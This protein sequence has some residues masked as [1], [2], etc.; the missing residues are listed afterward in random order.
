MVRAFLAFDEILEDWDG[1]HRGSSDLKAMQRVPTN[2]EVRSI[3]RPWR[4]ARWRDVAFKIWTER[5]DDEAI[6]LRTHY[7]DGS[8]AKFAEWRDVDEDYDPQYD[9]KVVLWTV[10]DDTAVF[11]FGDEWW[12]VFDVLPELAGPLQHEHTRGPPYVHDDSVQALRGELRRDVERRLSSLAGGEH[13][14]PEDAAVLEAEY[15]VH[16][17]MLQARAVSTFLLVADAGAWETDCLRLLY[18]D[19]KGN[20]VRHSAVEVSEAWETRNYWNY[21]KFCESNWWP[22]EHN[23]LTGKR[24]Q[25]GSELGDKYRARGE[26][27]RLLYGLDL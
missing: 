23:L 12:R 24:G 3:L 8:D 25:P 26:L 9:E 21:E 4:P 6:W 15:G 20:V 5:Y 19:G 10:L 16:G 11:N 14:R 1:T 13:E 2:D 27:G 17:E 7:G 18:L 22:H